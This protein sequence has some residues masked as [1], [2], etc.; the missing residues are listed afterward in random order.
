MEVLNPAHEDEVTA[1]EPAPRLADLAGAVVGV[2]SNGK[3]K[4]VPFFDEME[5]MLREEYAVA[6][7]V[8]VVK[9]NYSAPAPDELM[10]SARGWDAVLAGVGD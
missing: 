8:R 1:G 9:P 6:D 10:A 5:R 2:I 3:E 7:V 4:T